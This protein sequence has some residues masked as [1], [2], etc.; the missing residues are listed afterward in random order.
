MDLSGLNIGGKVGWNASYKQGNGSLLYSGDITSAPN[1]AVEYLHA[2]NGLNAPTLVNN[3][4]YSGKV[5]C[6]YKIVI[7]KGSD[8]HKNYMMDPNEVFA[9]I[10]CSSVQH[11]TVL[12]ML[13]PEKAATS[14]QAQS[15]YKGKKFTNFVTSVGAF[16]SHLVSKQRKGEE[17]QSFVLLNFGADMHEFREIQKYPIYNVLS[18]FLN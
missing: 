8:I 3:N 9:E 10:K 1:G 11:Q 4:V 7:G 6:A 18:Y 17:K 13:L 12:G 15:V 2:A 14:G 16:K 5:D